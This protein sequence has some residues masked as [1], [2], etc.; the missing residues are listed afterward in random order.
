MELFAQLR[1]SAFSRKEF[2]YLYKGLEI[3]H[4]QYGFH[5]KLWSLL[6]SILLVK[7]SLRIVPDK[8]SVEIDGE[9]GGEV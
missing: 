1:F 4:D 2:T 6:F 9:R 7:F 5:N 3:Q 8:A